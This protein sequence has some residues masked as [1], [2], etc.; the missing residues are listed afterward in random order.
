MR[1]H[2]SET[3]RSPIQ[4]VYTSITMG[5]TINAPETENL[6]DGE[7]EFEIKN[8]ANGLTIGLGVR[9]KRSPV[10]VADSP[11]PGVSVRVKPRTV[12]GGAHKTL[13]G[14]ITLKII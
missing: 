3:V 7:D 8:R 13:K 9:H 5:S 1:G 2:S 6:V 12:R 11:V 14:G 10:S 4:H